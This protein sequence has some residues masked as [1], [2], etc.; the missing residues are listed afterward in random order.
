MLSLQKLINKRLHA[1]DFSA[2]AKDWKNVCYH[3]I[4]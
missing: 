3:Q 1:L 4:K 2:K